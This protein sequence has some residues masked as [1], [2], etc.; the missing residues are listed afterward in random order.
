MTPTLKKIIAT[1]TALLLSLYVA[2]GFGDATGN[3]YTEGKYKNVILMIGDG[4]GENTLA[5]TRKMHGVTLS[6]DSM[7]VHGASDTN[8]FCCAYTDSAAGGTALS[9]GLR[10]CINTV[11]M[12]ALNEVHNSEDVGVPINLCELAKENGKDA[13]VVT[14]D[15]TSG[16]TPA[17]FSA[18]VLSRK[19]EKKI[20]SD[21]L[22]SDLDLIWGCATDSITEEKCAANGFDYIETKSEMDALES[23]SR[24][25]AQFDFESVKNVR[26]D[27]DSPYLAEMTEKAIDLLDDNENGFFL[28]VEGACIDKFSH[29]NDFDGCTK[30]VIEFSK[31]LEVALDYAADRDDTLVVVTADHE[32]GGIKLDKKTGEYKYTTGNHSIADVPVFVSAD[33]AGFKD[34]ELVKNRQIAV[35]IARVMGYG[36]DKFPAIKK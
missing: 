9:T 21:Q 36:E 26:R 16:A 15:K 35:Q 25:F 8:S 2:A 5:V 19:Q 3:D 30:N 11:G 1:M 29:D 31:A 7:P 4:M 14:T 28:M 27:N 34:G 17:S 13:G 6:M 18:H 33:D 20:C 32:T 23:G 22:R 10:T 24:S 12:F